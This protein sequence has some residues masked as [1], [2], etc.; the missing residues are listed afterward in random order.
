MWL[1]SLHAESYQTARAD[2]TFSRQLTISRTALIGPVLTEILLGFRLDGQADWV[3]Q[4]VPVLVRNAGSAND[5]LGRPAT[6]AMRK[7]G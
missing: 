6:G 1:V 3:T 2:E 4:R 7:A 5:R